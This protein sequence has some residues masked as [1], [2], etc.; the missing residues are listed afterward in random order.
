MSKYRNKIK[1]AEDGNYKEI[2]TEAIWE[3]HGGKKTKKKTTK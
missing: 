3:K 1:A 2:I